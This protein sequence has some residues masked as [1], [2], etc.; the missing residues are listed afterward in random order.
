MHFYPISIIDG[1]HLLL[2]LSKVNN[3][4]AHVV[5]ALA[6]SSIN[7]W[8]K[9]GVHEAFA[10]L[11]QLHFTLH[12]YVNVVNYLLARLCFPNAVASNNNK[13]CLVCDLVHLAIRH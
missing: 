2:S 7:I 13:I 1:V 3:D 9:K 5:A 12:L 11:C 6:L 8:G 10:Y 4:D